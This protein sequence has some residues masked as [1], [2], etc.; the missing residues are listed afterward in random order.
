MWGWARLTGDICCPLGLQ[1]CRTVYSF[2]IHLVL[3]NTHPPWGWDPL[4]SLGTHLWGSTWAKE[5]VGT[6]RRKIGKDTFRGTGLPPPSNPTGHQPEGSEYLVPWGDLDM[7][8]IRIC[9]SVPPHSD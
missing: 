7:K 8:Q 6:V 4:G 1:L 2:A 5:I 3:F 9:C